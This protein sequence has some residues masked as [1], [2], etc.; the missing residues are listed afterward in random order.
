MLFHILVLRTIFANPHQKALS[1][2]GDTV[3]SKAAKG[4][5]SGENVSPGGNRMMPL[6]PFPESLPWAMAAWFGISDTSISFG[7]FSVRCLWCYDPA[8]LEA[9][10]IADWRHILYLTIPNCLPAIGY[11]LHTRHYAPQQLLLRRSSR[12][13]EQ[14]CNLPHKTTGGRRSLL[15]APVFPGSAMHGPGPTPT[16]DGSH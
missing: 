1:S 5:L 7:H 15:R 12:C 13:R 8:V 10:L 9:G 16:L 4:G 3:L 6:D 14:V 11:Q 2:A